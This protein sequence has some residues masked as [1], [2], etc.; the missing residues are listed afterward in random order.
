[1][2]EQIPTEYS[3]MLQISLCHVAL[4]YANFR[5]Y[6]FLKEQAI[7]F[8]PSK[9]AQMLSG[10]LVYLWVIQCISPELQPLL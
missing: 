4:S 2:A 6:Q 8:P 5:T 10:P 1:M 9:C 7:F 3:I